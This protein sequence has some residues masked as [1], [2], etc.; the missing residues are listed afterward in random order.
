MEGPTSALRA[1]FETNNSLAG[2][3]TLIVVIGVVVEFAVLLAFSK[4]MNRKEKA[5]LVIGNILVVIGVGGEWW[6]GGQA[7]NAAE[8]LQRAS[9]E[10]VAGLIAEAE[11]AKSR[12]AN[13]NEEAAKANERAGQAIRDAAAANQ[14]AASLEKEAAAARERAATIERATEAARAEAAQ[15]T[16]TAVAASEQSG[17]TQAQI[18]WRHL[19]PD[20]IEKLRMGLQSKRHG[21][22]TLRQ[23]P[24]V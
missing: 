10:R 3:A 15:A 14:R 9:D 18:A 4:E 24:A 5:W 13:A 16:A 22:D 11:T 17:R 21:G 6:Y 12:I 20:Q 8:G 1:T 7:S 19:D 2:W 23:R